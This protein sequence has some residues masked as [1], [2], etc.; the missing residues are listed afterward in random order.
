MYSLRIVGIKGKIMKKAKNGQN[1]QNPCF[2][3]ES[4]SRKMKW[5]TV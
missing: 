3:G 5:L 4:I 1:R 2:Q